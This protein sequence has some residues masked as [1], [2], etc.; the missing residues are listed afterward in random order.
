MA[1]A[2]QQMGIKTV[3]R[4][5]DPKV[6][7]AV[8]VTTLVRQLRSQY[9]GG[10]NTVLIGQSTANGFMT[11]TTEKGIIAVLI[12]LLLPAVQKVRDAASPERKALESL[13]KPAGTL[14]LVM[15]DSTVQ[16][17]KTGRRALD[18]EGYTY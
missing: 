13:L 1:A 14:G 3:L 8:D 16:D 10:A 4:P 9:P 12:G 6:T 7:R 2:L 18:C 15:A 11:L 17:A 5:G